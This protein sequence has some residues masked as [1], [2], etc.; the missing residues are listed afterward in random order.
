MQILI[1]TELSVD[2]FDGLSSQAYLK[3]KKYHT[4]NPEIYET[5]KSYALRAIKRG[6]KRLS[7]ELIIN[8]IRW[9]TP[10]RAKDDYFKINNDFKPFYSRMFMN[11]F[12]EHAGFFQK[13]AS[14]ADEIF[15]TRQC[16]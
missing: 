3:F 4:D 14:K 12:P 9:E 5:F 15:F 2:Q 6:F 8:I 11:E 10:I 13:R 1:Q 7:A 16:K